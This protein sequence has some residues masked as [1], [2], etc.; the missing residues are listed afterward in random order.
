MQVWVVQFWFR[1]YGHKVIQRM[2]TVNL[3]LPYFVTTISGNSFLLQFNRVQFRNFFQV[4]WLHSARNARQILI[5]ATS[6][7]LHTCNKYF[8]KYHLR[9]KAWRA[10]ECLVLTSYIYLLCVWYANSRQLCKLC[11]YAWFGCHDKTAVCCSLTLASRRWISWF[12][13]VHWAI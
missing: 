13:K 2:A 5:S 11:C 4:T 1:N 10:T 3:R 9:R 6:S 8:V 12:L 7:S